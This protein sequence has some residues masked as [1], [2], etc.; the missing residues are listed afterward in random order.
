MFFVGGSHGREVLG[1][2]RLS[3]N[4]ASPVCCTSTEGIDASICVLLSFLELGEFLPFIW[5]C[6]TFSSHSSVHLM[7]QRRREVH[8]MYHMD[9]LGCCALAYERLMPLQATLEWPL[10]PELTEA[11]IHL[12]GIAADHSMD[13]IECYWGLCDAWPIE[14]ELL[15]QYHTSN[16]FEAMLVT[17]AEMDERRSGSIKAALSFLESRVLAVRYYPDYVFRRNDD[18]AVL[19]VFRVGCVVG[20]L[21]VGL[22]DI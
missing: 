14:S 5:C 18:P 21:Y 3:L 20:S 6:R 19:F 7:R 4:T 13:S 8:S 10:I 12:T 15:S 2:T 11:Q 22:D 17:V 9:H 16:Y 1:N